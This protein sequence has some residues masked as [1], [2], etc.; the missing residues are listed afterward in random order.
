MQSLSETVASLKEKIANKL[1]LSGKD[2]VLED[3]KSLAHYSVGAGEIL[4]LTL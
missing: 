1:I 2:G 3:N 4:T